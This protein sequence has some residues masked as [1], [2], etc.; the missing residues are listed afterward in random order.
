MFWD[1][2]PAKT[3]LVTQTHVAGT[4]TQPKPCLGHEP[5]QNLVL[6]LKPS[7]KHKTWF[8]DIMK[9]R[10]LMSHHRKNSVRDK[11]IGKK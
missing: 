8:Q 7:Q 2:N 10:F 3:L 5:S 11:V 4:G 9:L 6:G 1:L